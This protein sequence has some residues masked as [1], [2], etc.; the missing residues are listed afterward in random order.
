[1]RFLCSKRMVLI[2]YY[3]KHK[4]KKTILNTSFNVSNTVLRALHV[5]AYLIFMN[6]P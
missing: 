6:T 2:F 5:L 1:M 3:N 4:Q